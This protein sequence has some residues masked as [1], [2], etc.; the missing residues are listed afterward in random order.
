MKLHKKFWKAL[1]LI[2]IIG[3]F[4]MVLITGF[5]FCGEYVP[6]SYL[7]QGGTSTCTI[8]DIDPC[9]IDNLKHRVSELEWQIEKAKLN[10]RI[11]ELEKEIKRLQAVDSLDYLNLDNQAIDVDC[12]G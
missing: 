3:V 7:L 8:P 6:G 1:T 11:K 2:L 4:A 10:D 9:E 12:S 5:G